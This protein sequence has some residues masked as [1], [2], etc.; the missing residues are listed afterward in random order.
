LALRS[1]LILGHGPIPSPHKTGRI[2][3]EEH[4]NLIEY[5][6]EFYITFYVISRS[7]Y[8]SLHWVNY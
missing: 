3:E 6:T 1:L 7:S 5:G 4:T 8:V 2:I